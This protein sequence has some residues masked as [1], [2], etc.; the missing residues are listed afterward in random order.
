MENT[1]KKGPG[2]RHL[3]PCI[4]GYVTPSVMTPVLIIFEVAL[5]IL[6]PL[7][8]AAL[9]DG[10]LYR[11]EQFQLQ[12]VISRLPYRNNLQFVLWV[13]GLMVLA[14]LLSLLCGALAARTSAV[15]SMG[16]AKN[17]RERI[18]GKILQFSFKN[19]D[20][21]QT[22]SLVIRA[23]TDVNNLQNTYQMFLRMMFRAPIMMVLA[24]IMAFRINVKLSYIF[25]IALPLVLTPMLLFMFIG[26]KRFK[27]MFT[28]M[29]TMNSAV[30][31]D[32]IGMRV[33]KSF[34]RGPYEIGRFRNSADDLMK[35]QIYAQKLFSFA[36]PIQLGVMWGATILLWLFGGRMSVSPDGNLPIGEL[37]ALIGYSTQVIASL[38]MVSMFPLMLSRMRA[39]LDRINEV[40]EEQI[41][42]ESPESDLTVETGEIEF[43]HVDFSYSG[44]PEVLNLKDVS[45]HILPGQTVGIIGGTGE[46]KSTLVQMIP[47][48]YDV[49]SGAV[50]VSGHDV[51]EYGLRALRDGVSMVLQ[52]NMLFSG[53]IRENMRWGDP[54]ATDE[55]IREA[56]RIACADGFVTAFPDGYDTDL[57]QGGCNVSGGQK[58][59]LCIARALLKKPKILILDDSTSAVDTATEAKIRDGLKKLTDMT[60]I[61]IA[62]RITSIMG[63]DQIIVMEHGAISDVGTHEELLRRSLIY[64]EVYESQVR[65]EAN[66]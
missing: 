7:L 32:L 28:K 35:T 48:L 38:Q 24:A 5:E 53:S 54:D 2:L 34:V 51:R 26:R 11:V 16:F 37:T 18:F 52:K 46:G 31:E 3:K 17:L 23:T 65:E 66:A 19:T 44:N 55:Q 10:G 33:V 1:K 13:G 12:G 14:S 22:S 43:D 36:S 21:F 50:R 61:I 60:K 56:C 62:Q 15:A 59:R 63:A 30:Q 47:R 9:V 58:Q 41:D 49:L 57:G 25:V 20:R 40:F 6:I 8:M 4:R 45:L 27:M 64:R 39:S 29:D 42:I